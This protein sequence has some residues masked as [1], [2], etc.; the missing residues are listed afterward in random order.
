MSEIVRGSCACGKV[1]FEAALPTRFVSHCHCENCRHA[2]GAAFVTW[3]GFPAEAFRWTDGLDLL[4][5]WTTPTEATRCFCSL[6][7]CTM[8]FA[9]PRWAGEVHV[10]VACLE[11]A[12]DRMPS[13]HVF[14]DRSPAWAGIHDALPRF[15][16]EDG[17][18]PLDMP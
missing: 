5:E 16:G 13:G 9:S 2:H 6:C 12:L 8:T 7:G 11:E 10:A 3:A 15:G 17:V 4:Q 14:A 18:T 1:R